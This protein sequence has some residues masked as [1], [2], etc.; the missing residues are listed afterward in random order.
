MLHAVDNNNKIC[1]QML[2]FTTVICYFHKIRTDLPG[3][4][5]KRVSFFAYFV[6]PHALYGSTVGQEGNGITAFNCDRSVSS[7]RTPVETMEQISSMTKQHQSVKA[8]YNH[9]TSALV[10]PRKHILDWGPD[11]NAE[12]QFLG[13]RPCTSKLDDNLP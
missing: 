4:S 9:L 13:D 10:D 7:V 1:R 11:P 6:F 3:Y 8:V 2:L 12:G 5:R